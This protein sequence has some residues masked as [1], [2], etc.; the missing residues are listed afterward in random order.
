MR[1]LK[2]NAINKGQGVRRRNSTLTDGLTRER[3]S[4]RASGRGSVKR[5]RK[6]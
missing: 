3:E 5:E 6:D 2:V 4:E 1:E